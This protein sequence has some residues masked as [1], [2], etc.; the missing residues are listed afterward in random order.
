MDLTLFGVKVG[1]SLDTNLEF[2]HQIDNMTT[3]HNTTKTG[4]DF[5]EEQTTQITYEIIDVIL[6]GV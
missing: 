6:A 1:E 2:E 3:P 4:L 5:D